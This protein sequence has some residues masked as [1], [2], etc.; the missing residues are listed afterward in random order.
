[1]GQRGLTHTDK[2]INAVCYLDTLYIVKVRHTDHRW[3]SGQ[4]FPV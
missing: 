4:P 3:S 2:L 1:M